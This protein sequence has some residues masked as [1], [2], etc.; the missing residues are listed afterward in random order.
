[1]WN[2]QAFCTEPNCTLYNLNTV[3]EKEEELAEE[4]KTIKK[5]IMCAI[6]DEWWGEQ[7]YT[8]EIGQEAD[9]RALVTERER[10]ATS[11][12]AKSKMKK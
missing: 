1:M 3:P 11:E 12:K 7:W 4:G 2:V 10:A 8:G 9:N 6:N 5:S